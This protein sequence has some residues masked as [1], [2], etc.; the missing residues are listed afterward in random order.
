MCRYITCKGQ[1]NRLGTMTYNIGLQ[2]NSQIDVNALKSVTTEIID[3]A[4]LQPATSGYKVRAIQGVDLYNSKDSAVARQIAMNN[5][6]FNFQVSNNL[7]EKLR[8][9][10]TLAA[11]KTLGETKEALNAVNEEIQATYKA[12]KPFSMVRS[13]QVADKKGGY[14]FIQAA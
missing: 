8:Y 10:N 1:W 4:T 5:A 9:L 13:E 14:L 7:S 6:G 3:N 2:S 12:G 11:T